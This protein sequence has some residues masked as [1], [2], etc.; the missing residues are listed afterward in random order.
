MAEVRVT[1]TR[2]GNSFIVVRM[3]MFTCGSTTSQTTATRMHRRAYEAIRC[4]YKTPCRPY[5][6]GGMKEGICSG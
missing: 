2:C 4:A 5:T 6:F 3:P 1:Y